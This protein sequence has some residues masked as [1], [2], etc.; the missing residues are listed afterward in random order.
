MT[1]LV[2]IDL[3]IIG[4]IVLLVLIEYAIRAFRQG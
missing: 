4:G 3:V 1:T 2:K